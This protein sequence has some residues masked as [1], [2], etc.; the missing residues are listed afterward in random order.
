ASPARQWRWREERDPVGALLPDVRHTRPGPRG[1]PGNARRPLAAVHHGAHAAVLV[2]A[3]VPRRLRMGGPSHVSARIGGRGAAPPLALLVGH[4]AALRR[5]GASA[6]GTDVFLQWILLPRAAFHRVPWR[7][8]R[9]G[10]S[11]CF[12]APLDRS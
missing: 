6:G 10:A 1:T 5:L 7:S 8:H 2:L 4:R 9:G 3:A 12:I 11:V